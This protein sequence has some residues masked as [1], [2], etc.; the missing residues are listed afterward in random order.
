[1]KGVGK[2]SSKTTGAE[3]DNV[4]TISVIKEANAFS[5]DNNRVCSNGGSREDKCS[6]GMTT[7]ENRVGTTQP[8]FYGGR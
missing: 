5:A 1:M 7:A 2:D 4:M 3:I 6:N 8:I